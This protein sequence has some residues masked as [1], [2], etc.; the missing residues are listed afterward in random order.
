MRDMGVADVSPLT[1]CLEGTKGLMEGAALQSTTRRFLAR[2][3]CSTWAVWRSFWRCP[4]A[5]SAPST[6]RKMLRLLE[7]QPLAE[8]HEVLLGSSSGGAVSGA[9]RALRP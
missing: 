9:L 4:Q 1:N 6:S 5:F 8:A 3:V 2:W 7:P